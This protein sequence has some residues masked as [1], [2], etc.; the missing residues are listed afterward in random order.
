[1][2]KSWSTDELVETFQLAHAVSALHEMGILASLEK[3]Q[4]VHK[5][6]QHYRTDATL[7]KGILDYVAARTNL[8]RKVG[9]TFV[10]TRH[11]SSAAR[12]LLDLYIGAYGT[13][14]AQLPR[15]LRK[16]S[17]AA[18]LVD[19]VKYAHA[20]HNAGDSVLGALVQIILHLNLKHVL[21]LGCGPA[22]LLIA[23]AR[24]DRHLI[25]WGVELN[26]AMHRLARARIQEAQLNTRIRIVRG[27]CRE[28]QSVL[29]LPAVENIDVVVASQVAN[30]MF[31][32]GQTTAVAWLRHIRQTLPGRLLL[33]ADYYGRLGQAK[34]PLSRETL[35]HD[36]VQL[37]SGQGIPPSDA[38]LWGKVYTRSNCHLLHII[39]DKATSRFVHVL[40]L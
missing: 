14:A 1:M 18:T 21:D 9:A 30:E 33:I 25:G 10:V 20:F 3:P 2:T 38:S 28:L 4:T 29:P 34:A 26:P 27:D 22:A 35:L 6:S 11:Y 15:I 7:L 16:P 17:T 13:N 32:G 40:Q 24:K 5:L 36:Y 23:L 8:L 39:E 37:I 31:R 12:F 19:H